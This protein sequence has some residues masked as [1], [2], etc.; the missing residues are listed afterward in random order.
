MVSFFIN[1]KKLKFNF[2]KTLSQEAK[3]NNEVIKLNDVKE[4]PLAVEFVEEELT[5]EEALNNALYMLFFWCIEKCFL[6]FILLRYLGIKLIDEVDSDIINEQVK[7][8]EIEIK[9]DKLENNL[10][11]FSFCKNAKDKNNSC[12]LR[13]HLFRLKSTFFRNVGDIEKSKENH[14]EY[15]KYSTFETLFKLKKNQSINKIN[16]NKIALDNGERLIRLEKILTNS[17]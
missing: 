9:I 11:K 4:L 16:E 15:E 1:L 6:F 3:N 14:K 17:M 13:C 12:F 2:N 10:E 5:E 8:E 7:I